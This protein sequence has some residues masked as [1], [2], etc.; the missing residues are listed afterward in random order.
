MILLLFGIAALIFKHI[1][2]IPK[3]VL[4]GGFAVIIYALII[5][6]PILVDAIAKVV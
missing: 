1:E 2:W 6:S 5:N 3:L 4:A